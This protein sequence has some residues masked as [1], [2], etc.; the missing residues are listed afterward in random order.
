LKKAGV[1]GVLVA[2]ALHDGSL[3]RAEFEQLSQS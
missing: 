3:G 1:D 2:S